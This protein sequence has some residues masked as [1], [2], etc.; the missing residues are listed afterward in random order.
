MTPGGGGGGTGN[1]P[2][3]QIA[4][5][6]NAGESQKLRKE[7]G[8]CQQQSG[9]RCSIAAN[10]AS[11]LDQTNE[12][13]A[14]QEDKLAIVTAR[15]GPSVTFHLDGHYSV[16][17]RADQQLIEVTRLDFKPEYF[18]KAVPVLTTHVYRQANL[19]NDST[20][21][22]LPGDATMYVGKDFVG[23]MTLPLV[24]LGE[25]FSVGFG[26]DPQIQVERTLVNKTQSVQ[27][28]NQVHVYDFRIRISNLKHGKSC[29]AIVGSSAQGRVKK[30]A[31]VTLL[32]P[33]PELSS[34][35]QFVREEKPKNLLRLGF[36]SGP[37]QH[38]RQSR[39][40]EL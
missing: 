37:R 3:F 16:P 19:T 38:R 7:A 18:Y 10:G 30:S 1:L 33:R 35:P 9:Q 22:F 28:G 15:E 32:T 11:A 12:L 27:G 23:R 36:E 39:R 29:R 21:V 24:A 34:D 20:Y 8:I 31:G 13:L 2:A 40:G 14:Q 17:S 26:V 25:P 6:I 4:T 5:N